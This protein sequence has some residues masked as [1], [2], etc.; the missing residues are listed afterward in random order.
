MVYRST[1]DN[2]LITTLSI[3]NQNDRVKEKK[4]ENNL[5]SQMWEVFLILACDN[6]FYVHST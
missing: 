2:L 5:M 1:H 3:R 4:N 6:C